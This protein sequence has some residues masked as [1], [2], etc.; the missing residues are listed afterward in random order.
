MAFLFN[1]NLF[2]NTYNLSQ[3]YKAFVKLCILLDKFEPAL[4]SKLF[5][6]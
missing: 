3:L 1:L 4:V 2:Y 5:N 6:K